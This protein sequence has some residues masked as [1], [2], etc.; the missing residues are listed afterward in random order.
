MI[1]NVK[2]LIGDLV[3]IC[4][5]STFNIVSATNIVSIPGV[6]ET[7]ILIGG[8]WKINMSPSDGFWRNESTPEMWP[9]IFVP[10]EPA[11]QG[12]KV[13]YNKPFVYKKQVVI[14]DDYQGKSIFIGFD[15]VYSYARVWINGN[16]VRSHSGGFTSWDCD[17]TRFV[18][19]GESAWLTV[20]VTD[21]KDDI[22]GASAYAHHPIGGILRDVYLFARPVKHIEQLHIE[23]DFDKTFTDASLNLNY[24]V[25]AGLPDNAEL[26]FKLVDM[27]GKE[28]VL[29]LEKF[30]LKSRA[31]GEIK[32]AVKSPAKWEAEH[33]NLYSFTVA[34]VAGGKTIETVTQRI[35]FRK[36]TIAGNQLLVNGKNVRLR[37]TCRHDV[38]A[39][40]GRCTTKELDETDAKLIKEANLNYVRTSHYPPSQTFLD[41]CD[42]YGIYVEEETAV[43]FTQHGSEKDTAYTGRYLSQFAE[44]IERDRNHPGVIMWS[45]GN[46]SVWGVNFQKEYEYAKANDPTRPVIFPNFGGIPDGVKCFDIDYVHYPTYQ[47]NN[48]YHPESRYFSNPDEVVLNDE[49]AHVPCYMT[50]TLKEEQG[51]RDFWGESIKRFWD[52]MSASDGA[53][54]A[55]W[56]M[57]DEYFM[58][59]DSCKG[60]GEWGWVDVWR[61]K[62]PE[63]WHVKKAHSPVRVMTTSIENFKAGLPL[64]ISVT[65]RYDF[66]NLNELKISW[67]SPKTSGI[68]KNADIAPRSKG[69]IEIPANKWER[70]D[71]ISLQFRTKGN[72]LVDAYQISLGTRSVSF[73]YPP[74]KKLVKTETDDRII[75][76]TGHYLFRINKTS[77]LFDAILFDKDTLIRNGPFLNLSA[78]NPCHE[79]F[80]SKCPITTW[81]GKDWKLKEL[82]TEVTPTMVKI[83]SKGT[84]DSLAVNFEF[85]I[86]SGGVFSIGYEIENPPSWQI[87]ETGIWFKLPDQYRQISWDRNALWSLYPKDHIG[88]PIG[89]ALLYNPGTLESYRTAPQH[90]WDM[91]SKCGYFYYGPKGTD[92]KF[93]DLVNE[94]K[95]LKTSLNFYQLIYND[96]VK[97][98]RVESNG[99]T[100]ARLVKSSFGSI[101]LLVDN[102][103]DYVNL[104]WGNYERNI[105]ITNNYKNLIRFRLTDNNSNIK[106]TY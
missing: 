34:L 26:H 60:T 103:W 55:I 36:I 48:L 63:F 4:F 68:I 75:V 8:K 49:W 56:C 64:L 58:L 77:G 104:N 11:M 23:T 71:T 89:K 65:N 85:L 29:P 101:N 52:N 38:S 46:E 28:V 86:R 62:K 45:L 88:R 59:P 33:P 82:K 54:G 6:K 13:Q 44:M 14:P 21:K 67:A 39:D 12:F 66:T 73:T 93:R 40:Y 81:N 70:G 105:H 16:L 9:E 106:V 102:E 92:K 42:K 7:K 69:V 51:A 87:Q 32:I 50:E 72:Q 2:K 41:Y 47:G 80:Y 43:C 95:C 53:G 18:K 24:K 1:N 22:S 79:V 83:I 98:L 84:V 37:G 19:A 96:G 90:S 31:K 100:A 27:Q 3:L 78:M 76:S 57:V 94:A 20:E 5:L 61:R 10:G 74:N 99:S 30:D 17:I 25:S 35:G 91:D 15:G 97:R